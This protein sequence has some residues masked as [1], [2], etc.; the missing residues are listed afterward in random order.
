MPPQAVMG[1]V[2]DVEIDWNDEIVS[3]KARKTNALSTP[4]SSRCV[5]F[6]ETLTVHSI[7]HHSEMTREE[8]DRVWMNSFDAYQNQLN[9]NNTVFLVKTGVGAQLSEDDDFCSRGLEHYIDESYA[10]RVRK[11]QAI[12][13]AMQRFLKRTGTSSPEMIAKAYKKYTIASQDVA[14]E[15]ALRDQQS[16]CR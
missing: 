9:V 7:P 5:T 3:R 4:K 10:A 1:D 12:A 8:C 6:A 2:A 11:S 15:T 13:L 14:Y 16:S